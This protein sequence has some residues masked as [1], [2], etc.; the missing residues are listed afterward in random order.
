MDASAT[1]IQD[2]FG[3]L[4][5]IVQYMYDSQEAM[6]RHWSP[7]TSHPTLPRESEDFSR[8][9]KYAKDVPLPMFLAYLKPV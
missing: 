7:S 9:G 1:F 2:T 8:G 6:P 4:P 5:R 3:T